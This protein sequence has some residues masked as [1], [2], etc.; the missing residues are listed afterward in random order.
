M[1]HSARE[2]RF[3][4][5]HVEQQRKQE[6]LN[7]GGKPDALHRYEAQRKRESKP[8]ARAISKIQ[9]RLQT[10][11]TMECEQAKLGL[12]SLGNAAASMRRLGES[13]VLLSVPDDGAEA[14]NGAK[15]IGSPRYCSQ[16]LR[17][18]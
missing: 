4:G 17:L 16:A 8:Q 15:K 6:L 7:R 3:A 13:R 9:K 2:A 18:W 14:M 10:I 12:L 5:A 11:S 1:H